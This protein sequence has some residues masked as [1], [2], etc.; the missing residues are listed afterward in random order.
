MAFKVAFIMVMRAIIHEHGRMRIM[1]S[2]CEKRVWMGDFFYWNE[3]DRQSWR[4]LHLN[5]CM[6]H[7]SL[8]R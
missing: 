1:L 8:I 2:L 4:Y 6:A 3:I 5:H 7:E